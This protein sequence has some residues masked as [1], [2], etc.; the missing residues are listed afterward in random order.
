M[1]EVLIK[2]L[3]NSLSVERKFL[4]YRELK[5]PTLEETQ[6][7]VRKAERARASR[8]GNRETLF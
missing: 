3:W 8:K 5:C 2:S 7:A 4:L 1:R 6:A